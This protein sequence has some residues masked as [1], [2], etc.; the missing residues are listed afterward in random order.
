M[1]QFAA[2]EQ[3]DSLA[4]VP[5]SSETAAI[6]GHEE[7]KAFLARTY[8]SGKM[9]HALLFGGPQGV[10]KATLAF[11]FVVQLLRHP[12]PEAAPLSVERP[13][14]SSPLFRQVAGHSHPGVLHLMRPWDEKAKKFKTAITVEEIRS[15]SRFVGLT[16]HDGGYRAVIIDSADDMNRNAANALLKNLEE[17]PA[18]TVFI[19]VSHAPGRLLPTIRSRCQ[20]VRFSPLAN[21]DVSKALDALPESID[22]RLRD[23]AVTRCGGSVREAILLAQ[24]GGLEISTAIEEFA[25]S[26]RFDA[27]KANTISGA[28]AGKGNDVQFN[29][30]NAAAL[31]LLSARARDAARTGDTNT[32]VQY[33]RLW[34]ETSKQIGETASYNLDRKQ[35]VLSVLANLNMTMRN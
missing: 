27:E 10:G 21:A 15:I 20:Y 19:L 24:F 5:A 28:V 9:P 22:S 6:F 25:S 8:K 29:L 1:S 13:D 7:Q 17:P 2:P 34:E 33:S 23:E 18:K 16:A 14:I 26:A 4:G 31:E 35:H 32:S 30:F 3:Y 12:N 11:Q